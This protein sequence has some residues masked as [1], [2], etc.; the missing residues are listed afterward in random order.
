P[1]T[2]DQLTIPAIE[3]LLA[4]GYY[5]PEHFDYK[6]MLPPKGDKSGQRRLLKACWAVANSSGGFF[7]FGVDDDKNKPPANR[8]VGIDPSEDFP[9]HF[10]NYPTKCSPTVRW[11]AGNPPLTLSNGNKIFVVYIP[12]SWN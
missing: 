5:E 6:Q 7:V 4:Q 8:L 3:Q 1:Q 9:E 10:G 2:I 12:R 11:E